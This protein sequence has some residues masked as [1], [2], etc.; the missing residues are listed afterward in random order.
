MFENFECLLEN[1]GNSTE[2]SISGYKSLKFNGWEEVMFKKLKLLKEKVKIT[3]RSI[4]WLTGLTASLEIAITPIAAFI[5]FSTYGLFNSEPLSISKSYSILIVF[6]LIAGP[7]SSIGMA[8]NEYLQSQVALVR[9][10]SIASIKPGIAHKNQDNNLDLG[11]IIIEKNDFCWT[12]K[13]GDS[14]IAD[15]DHKN[16]NNDSFENEY[17]NTSFA[18]GPTPLTSDKKKNRVIPTHQ[19]ESARKLPLDSPSKKSLDSFAGERI[20]TEAPLQTGQ[21][22]ADDDEETPF[23]LKD[24]DIHIFPGMLVAV[25]GKI[26]SG[27]SSFINAILGQLIAS[28]SNPRLNGRIAYIP[29]EPFLMNDTIRNNIL[30]GKSFEQEFY[31]HV[32]KLSQLTPDLKL[33]QNGDKTLVEESGSNLSGGQKQRIAIAR[34]IYS[35]ADIYLMDDFLSALDAEVGLKIYQRVLLKELADKTRIFTTNHPFTLKQSDIVL[36]LEEGRIMT[37]GTYQE[38]V[39][40]RSFRRACTIN[41]VDK[42]APKTIQSIEDIASMHSFNSNSSSDENDEDSKGIS[43]DELEEIREDDN[44]EDYEHNEDIEQSRQLKTPS[45]SCSKIEDSEVLSELGSHSIS[46]QPDDES[47]DK[48]RSIIET[49]SRLIDSRNKELVSRLGSI[50][51]NSSISNDKSS[52]QDESEDYKPSAPLPRGSRL[53]VD[54]YRDEFPITQGEAE[55]IVRKSKFARKSN[56]PAYMESRKEE[57]SDYN[58]VLR[59]SSIPRPST[60]EVT[61]VSTGVGITGQTLRISSSNRKKSRLQTILKRYDFH[62]AQTFTDIGANPLSTPVT[63]GA[64]ELPNRGVKR[65][66]TINPSLITPKSRTSKLGFSTYWKYISKGGITLFSLNIILQILIA[67]N[68]IFIDWWVGVWFSSK[69]QDIVGDFYLYIYAGAGVTLI[70]LFLCKSYLFAVFASESSANF[71][72]E[73]IWSLFRKNSKF[74]GN[75]STG[76]ILLRCI[77]DSRNLDYGFPSTLGPLFDFSFMVLFGILFS[78]Y[79]FPILLIFFLIM[80]CILWFSFK[81][82]IKTNIRIKELEEEAKAPFLTKVI[83]VL[84]GSIVLESFG[85]L[86]DAI[87][88][89]NNDLQRYM[90]C[91]LH[92]T[93]LTPWILFRQELSIDFIIFLMVLFM[94]CQKYIS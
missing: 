23:I 38:I 47:V 39:G 6:Y 45:Q 19:S 91:K 80:G 79:V 50:S 34:A 27:K 57:A 62:P 69:Y 46:L 52:R 56:T 55:N 87:K 30:F 75:T 76:D 9:L 26:G 54:A 15:K 8:V 18:E 84:K 28:N 13:H 77:N 32:M 41:N 90:D 78:I 35:K 85:A 72:Y 83:A 59:Q 73:V 86:D 4:L 36:V 61:N 70:I 37:K 42:M 63:V 74:F 11:E 31:D 16:I 64:P 51:Q 93:T 40:N 89:C 81:S 44:E 25:V 17:K 33:L 1:L 14:L 88:K 21:G 7:I 2:E 49:D 82:Y 68:R 67:T 5:S 92:S 10:D 29:Q 65:R 48:S 24:I 58:I 43:I 20:D 12:N 94:L 60:V 66:I 22:L 53:W 71:Y 3:E